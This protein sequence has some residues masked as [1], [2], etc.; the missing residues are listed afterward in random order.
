[1]LVDDVYEIQVDKSKMQATLI[2][3]VR[4]ENET[5]YTME[6]MKILFNQYG[7]IYGI[8]EIIVQKVLTGEI[9]LPVIIAEG[10]EPVNGVDATLKVI[11][12]SLS[13]SNQIDDIKN[14]DLKQVINIPS[15]THGQLIGQ[16]ITATK[17]SSG[18]N[19]FGEE[20]LAKSGKD[21]SLRPGKN[22]RVDDNGLMLYAMIDG[23]MSVEG[24]II[25]I[26]PVF[27]VNGDL[28]LKTGNI[29]FVGTVNIRG[30][31][32][33]G[34][35]IHSKGDIRIHGTVEG[36]VLIS[37]GSIYVSTG[38]VG[39][40]KGLIKAKGNLHTTFINQG[41]IE[42]EGDV[43]C[44]QS[45]LHSTVQADGTVYCHK[46]IGNIVGGSISAGKSIIAREVG[47]S[48][49][50]R[51]FLYL[52]ANQNLMDKEHA[53]SEKLKRAEDDL[54]KLNTLLQKLNEKEKI[55]PLTTN[56]KIIKLK[57]RNSLEVTI[58]ALME[59]KEKMEEL[60][61]VIGQFG[62]ST[63]IVE[64]QIYPNVDVHFGKYQQ[65]IIAPHQRVKIHLEHSEI[66][67]SKM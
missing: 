39:Q 16:K 41:I 66:V 6:D 3:K 18:K 14:V 42:V 36:A 59:A 27:E 46:G 5:I 24:K 22:T 38:I 61:E 58:D 10:Q 2:Q 52:G 37:G 32:P 17:G 23:Q 33:A 31:V 15:V 13:T 47:N 63:V 62:K 56:E 20:V 25:H 4:A 44:T 67:I 29:S 21:F 43:N 19:V 34:F 49:N 50:T 51:T 45:I 7:I 53:F 26:F 64:K 12:P 8:K 35:E 60:Q 54:T 30:N 9:A 28:D 11:Y 57:V 55:S 1:M 65:K 48:H 40:G